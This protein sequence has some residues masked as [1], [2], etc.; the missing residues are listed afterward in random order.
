MPAKYVAAA[1]ALMLLTGATTACA[2]DTV[3]RPRSA[4]FAAGESASPSTCPRGE[5]ASGALVDRDTGDNSKVEAATG[6][7]AK[8]V[9]RPRQVGADGGGHED[10]ATGTAST[11]T[12][13]SPL[14]EGAP[15]KATNA[16]KASGALRWQSLLPGVMK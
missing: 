12:D 10:S 15:G 5:V 4:V 9:S 2:E 14:G 11:S 8:A 13:V 6:V 3:P 1:T 7:A 16:H